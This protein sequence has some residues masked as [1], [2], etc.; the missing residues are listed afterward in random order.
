MFDHK[1]DHE[2]TTPFTPPHIGI[3]EIR[4]KSILDMAR[5]MLKQRSMPDSHSGEKISTAA[6]VMNRCSTKRL[7][8]KVRQEV[9]SGKKPYV[10]HVRVF[11]SICYKHVLDARME[12]LDGKSEAII[13]VGY[14]NSRAYR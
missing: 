8:N 7:N 6:Y 4:N 11:G 2:V 5:W 10:N 12:K 13:F 1:I 3:T 9:W 14:H